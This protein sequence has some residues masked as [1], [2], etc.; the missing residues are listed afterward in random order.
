VDEKKDC[1]FNRK[2]GKLT[3]TVPGRG[4]K[5]EYARDGGRCKLGADSAAPM[6]L[7]EVEGDFTV[8][9]RVAGAVEPAPHTR[10][11]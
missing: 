4:H 10:S 9:V 2:G 8:S 3:I 7:R 6:L 5:L 1:G 11:H